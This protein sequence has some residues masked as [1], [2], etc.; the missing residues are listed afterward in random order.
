M[1]AVVLCRASLLDEADKAPTE[2]TV[3]LVADRE[4]LLLDGRLLT[5]RRSPSAPIGVLQTVVRVHEDFRLIILAN[6]PGYPFHGNALFR[7]CG[8]AFAP[9]VVENPDAD[10]EEDLLAVVAPSRSHDERR[11]LPP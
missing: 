7:E 11:H 8:A 3:L 6:R 4:L 5:D 1:R 10:S 9:V 2:V